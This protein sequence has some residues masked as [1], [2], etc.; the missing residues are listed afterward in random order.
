[1]ERSNTFG[2]FLAGA[3]ALLAILI[4][5][6]AWTPQTPAK[7]TIYSYPAGQTGVDICSHTMLKSPYGIESNDCS[8]Y[9]LN[10]Y[11]SQISQASVYYYGPAALGY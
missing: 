2:V 10:P 4:L 3:I 7:A 9:Y 8:P 6:G 11:Y 5:V 1:M